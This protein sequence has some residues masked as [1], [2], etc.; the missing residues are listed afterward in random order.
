VTIVDISDAIKFTGKYFKMQNVK[1]HYLTE[2]DKY[3]FK[4]KA[5]VSSKPLIT[6]PQYKNNTDSEDIFNAYEGSLLL[7]RLVDQT[8]VFN[9]GR[10]VVP[11]GY[12]EDAPVF[13]LTF[14]KNAQTKGYRRG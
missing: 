5:V 14:S 9:R 7:T 8:A 1:V 12:P 13:E 3:D 11:D 4:T 6:S 10:S 2:G